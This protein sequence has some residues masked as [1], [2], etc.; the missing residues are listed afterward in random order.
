MLSAPTDQNRV[1]DP[2]GDD[3][4]NVDDELW[5][6]KL[7]RVKL[8]H[9]IVGRRNKDKVRRLREFIDTKCENMDSTTLD[10]LT[11]R[12]RLNDVCISLD[13]HSKLMKMTDSEFDQCMEALS[14][15]MYFPAEKQDSILER[16]TKTVSSELFADAE[17]PE[18]WFCSTPWCHGMKRR[19]HLR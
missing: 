3:E 6:R 13:S 1:E 10:L 7:K 11:S 16:R 8:H 18:P 17:V 4:E 9:T 19:S 15:N 5:G 2:M 12:L 14:G